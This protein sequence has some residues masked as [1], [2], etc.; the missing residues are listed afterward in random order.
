[1]VIADAT[2]FITLAKIGRITLLREVHKKVLMPPT[3]REEVIDSGRAINAVEVIHV[4]QGVRQEWI[5]VAILTTAEFGVAQQIADSTTLHMG[6]AEALAIAATRE[7]LLIVDDKEARAVANSME[8]E[9]M[10]TA[11]FL[12][13]AYLRELL[14]YEQL[15]EAIR[16]LA[17]VMWLSPGVVSE[18]LRTA[19]EV[20]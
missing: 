17:E 4:E 15:S 8:I 13:E 12:L 1:M 6:E 18:I 2:V 11:A 16:D 20:T 7:M 10:G 9:F 3:V 5:E 14:D 19:R